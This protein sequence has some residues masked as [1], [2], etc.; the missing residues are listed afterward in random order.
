MELLKSQK[1]KFSIFA[2]LEG[3]NKIKKKKKKKLKSIPNLLS[4][5][6]NHFS[7]NFNKSWTFFLVFHWIFKPFASCGFLSGWRTG[8][9]TN[10]PRNSNSNSNSKTVT[11]DFAFNLTLLWLHKK[12]TRVLVD[13]TFPALPRIRTR[14]SWAHIHKLNTLLSPYEFLDK[15]KYYLQNK[16]SDS[17]EFPLIS[18]FSHEKKRLKI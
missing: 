10:L 4:L 1:L 13:P 8:D 3:L 17:L 15:F 14:I 16:Y 9:N 5:Q 12:D 6:F 18:L 7:S 2:V 11:L